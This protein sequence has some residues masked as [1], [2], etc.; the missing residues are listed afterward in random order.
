MDLSISTANGSGLKP[1]TMQQPTVE[2][3]KTREKS[4]HE[5]PWTAPTCETYPRLNVIS[6]I[7]VVVP[8]AGTCLPRKQVT[9]NFHPLL[10]AWKK[11]RVDGKAPYK[12]CFSC[13][14]RN[15][16]FLL[17]RHHIIHQFH[18]HTPSRPAGAHGRIISHLSAGSLKDWPIKE[19]LSPEVNSPKLYLKTSYFNNLYFFTLYT[20]ARIICL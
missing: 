12:T 14:W 13:V 20:L 19:W 3:A 11:Q 15:L 4:L 17:A 18:C 5:L 6:A 10:W 8:L 9:M 2:K 1:R 16:M 7:L